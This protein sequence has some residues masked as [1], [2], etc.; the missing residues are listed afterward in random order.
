MLE[1]TYFISAISLSRPPVVLRVGL[2][3]Q[4]RAAAPSVGRQHRPSRSTAPTLLLARGKRS[5]D[6]PQRPKGKFSPGVRRE[7]FPPGLPLWRAAVLSH[8]KS[9]TSPWRADLLANPRPAAAV[10]SPRP[11]LLQLLAQ[12]PLTRFQIGVTCS[13][14]MID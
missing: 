3:E 13:E 10:G 14:L 11:A 7:P 5:R 12:R 6:P 8:M 9:W 1:H 2:L 4:S